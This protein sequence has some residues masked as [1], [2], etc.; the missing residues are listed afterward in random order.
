MTRGGLPAVAVPQRGVL[1]FR[2]WQLALLVAY[3]AV[4]IVNIQDQRRREPWLLALAAGGF[5][6]YGLIACLAWPGLR[7]LGRRLSTA[8]LLAVYLTGM[9]AL[10]LAATVTYLLIEYRYL[11]GH[12]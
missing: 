2:V 5:V 6:A 3:V 8:M 1:Q 11:V 10:F 7:R 4:A 9:S 12:F